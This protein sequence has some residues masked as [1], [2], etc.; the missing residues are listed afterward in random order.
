MKKKE[1]KSG[2][3]GE[4]GGW[5][6]G[7]NKTL[8]LKKKLKKK[9]EE[10]GEEEINWNSFRD[11]HLCVVPMAECKINAFDKHERAMSKKIEKGVE[12]LT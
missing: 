9:E 11:R 12:D 7:E 5:K 3:W 1:E 8:D 2:D 6:V 4:G 10:E